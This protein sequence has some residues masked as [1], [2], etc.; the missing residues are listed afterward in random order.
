[1]KEEPPQ[2]SLTEKNHEKSWIERVS[3]LFSSTPK[4]REEVNS[5]LEHAVEN[6]II[7]EDEFSIIEGAMEVTEIQARDVMVPRTQMIVVELDTKPQDFLKTI[8][9]SGHSRFPVI[10]ESIDDVVGILLAKDLLPL[11]SEQSFDN[12]DIQKLLRPVYKVPE[13]KRL[14]KLLRSF[15]ERHNHMAVVIDEYGSIS[16]LIT[17]E[18]ILEEIV[19]EIEDEYDVQ[20]DQ[21][22][23]KIGNNDFIIKAHMTIDDFNASFGAQLSSP[24]A[25]TIAGIV[26]QQLGHVP[27]PGESVTIDNFLFKVIHADNRRLHL[28]R[29]FTKETL[30]I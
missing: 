18:D 5:L 14:N 11:I 1:M 8:I 2:S 3:D 13:S 12:F 22:I 26:I 7:G 30:K 27:H 16:G 25:G 10:G 29:V 4:T 20:P 23:K 15:R 24:D 19:G 17:I 6:K 28:L 9:A 21:P